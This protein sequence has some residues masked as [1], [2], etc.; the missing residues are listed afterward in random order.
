MLGGEGGEGQ[1]VIGHVQQVGGRV[2]KPASVSLEVDVG[3]LGPGRL[4]V[5]L[6]EDGSHQGG[7]HR[8]VGLWDLGGQVGHEVGPAPL[9]GRLGQHRRDR[10]LDATVGVG[11]HQLDA[12]SPRATKR[13]Q[14]GRPGGA[15][16]SGHDV[17]AEDL[18]STLGVGGCGDDHRDVHHPA[19]LSDPLGHRV[20]PQVAIGALVQGSLFELG[21]LGSSRRLSGHLGLGDPL[22]AHGLDQVIDP[23][24]GHALHVGLADHGH[25][26][27]SRPASSAGSRNSGD[28]RP[29]R[30]L[31]T[32]SSTEPTRVSQGRIR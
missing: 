20:D 17:E 31:G 18:P 11:D 4:L 28:Q 10:R 29:F 9:P 13:A 25:Q 2:A 24:G 6:F 21:H 26:G 14:K 5:G 22:D 27:L 16:L 19:A 3:Q 30:G 32:A 23:A 1:D 7:D 8:P 15:V 12:G